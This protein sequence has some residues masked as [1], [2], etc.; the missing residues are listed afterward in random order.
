MT[1]VDF[2]SVFI[3]LYIVGFFRAYL[4]RMTLAID[5]FCY[6]IDL[7]LAPGQHYLINF[8]LFMKTLIKKVFLNK[9]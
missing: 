6:V 3:Y 1:S 5:F 4:V 7:A 2:F 9:S 8:P